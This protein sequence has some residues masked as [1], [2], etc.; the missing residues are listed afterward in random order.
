MNK[1]QKIL[2]K[3]FLYLSL[4]GVLVT[5]HL[6]IM[7]N[8]GFDR[9]CMGFTTSQVVEEAFDCESVLDSDGGSILGI[10][11]V[12]LGMTYYIF[13]VILQ[14]LIFS[15]KNFTLP[16]RVVRL[17]WIAFGLAYSIHLVYYQH[18]VLDE[19]CALC[20]LSA[21]TVLLLSILQSA[22]LIR[23]KCSNLFDRPLSQT[24]FYPVLITAI[25]GSVDF[26][27]FQSLEINRI[28]EDTS[29]TAV[30]TAQTDP[31][32][33]PTTLTSINES[34]SESCS[35]ND[36][37]PEI[38]NFISLANE[39]DIRV[40]NPGAANVIMEFFDPNCSHCKKLSRVMND[41]MEIYGE[42]AYFIF[43]PIPLWNYS[44]IQIQALYLAAEDGLFFQ[45]L[46][47]QFAR[48]KPRKGISLADLGQIGRNI[49][50]DGDELIQR[51]RDNEYREY[52][53]KEHRKSRDAGIKSAPT[54]LIN[55]KTVSTKSRTVDCIGALLD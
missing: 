10:S 51:I 9:G 6:F 55:G 26:L 38:P 36:S 11:N 42:D 45:M 46:E 20:L 13:F 39:Y 3:L 16:L 41:A 35:F 2:E 31:A 34:D 33:E 47:H 21:V 43:K 8:R 48:Q 54:L 32:S 49:G 37:K 28:I 30:E 14:V 52:I 53:M 18:F 23:F 15:L 25:I 40:G 12:Y 50:M 44:V 24:I 19:Y 7:S 17:L 4:F 29:L 22:Y 1:N 27:Y 5:I